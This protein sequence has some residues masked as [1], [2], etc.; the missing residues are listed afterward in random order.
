MALLSPRPWINTSVTM[1]WQKW[2]IISFTKVQLKLV[3]IT[4]YCIGLYLN[5]K[6]I[7]QYTYYILYPHC[8]NVTH[9]TLVVSWRTALTCGSSSESF[10]K[11]VSHLAR[12]ILSTSFCL[13]D[14]HQMAQ[15]GRR[16]L[17]G[18]QTLDPTLPMIQLDS[19]F[20]FG[21]SF[22]LHTVCDADFLLLNL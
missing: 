13:H 5:G 3:L 21:M 22:K 7:L 14:A 16:V 12:G 18:S 11:S 9:H 8:F 10:V 19:I 2:N 6:G 20:L 15:H 1:F 17:H 4:G